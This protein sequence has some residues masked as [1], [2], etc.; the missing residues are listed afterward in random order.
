MNPHTDAPL[1]VGNW[2]IDLPHVRSTYVTKRDGT[3]DEN[4]QAGYWYRDQACSSPLN[5]NPTFSKTG[6]ED[7]LPIKYSLHKDDYWNGD[8]VH[9]PQQGSTKLLT[10]DATFKR[11]N[12]KQWQ[13]DCVTESGK[14]EG[15]K[16]TTLDGTVYTMQ[17]KRVITDYQ[18]VG[19]MPPSTI[20]CLNSPIECLPDAF[21]PTASDG[22]FELLKHYIFLLVTKVEDKYGNTVVSRTYE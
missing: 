14:P 16:I 7:E 3:F 20:G 11:H 4:Q 9:I 1:Q 17:E 13:V 6:G 12:N 8:T 10:K 15:F 19:M 18:K 21:E 22:D 5:S 2:S